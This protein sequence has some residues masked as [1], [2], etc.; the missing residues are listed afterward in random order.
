MADGASASRALQTVPDGLHA[1][2]VEDARGFGACSAWMAGRY[3][4]NALLE[5]QRT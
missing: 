1:D 3:A 5:Q 4:E 2:G